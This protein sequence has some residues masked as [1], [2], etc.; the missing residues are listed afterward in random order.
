MILVIAISSVYIMIQI[1]KISNLVIDLKQ[2]QHQQHLQQQQRQIPIRDDIGDSKLIFDK[3]SACDACEKNLKEVKE[4]MRGMAVKTKYLESTKSSEDSKSSSSTSETPK[5][6]RVGTFPKLQKTEEQD[7]KFYKTVHTIYGLWSSDDQVPM[8]DLDTWKQH[9]PEWTLT[10]HNRKDSD[11][12]VKEKF[13]WL[14]PIYENAS[15]IQQADLLRLLFVYEYGGIY[16]DVDVAVDKPVEWALCNNGFESST[17]NLVAF[18]EYAFESSWVGGLDTALRNGITEIN[19]RISNY[20][21]YA[22]P[23]SPAL[24]SVIMNVAA[25]MQRWQTMSEE[26]R[27]DDGGYRDYATLYT[28]G[29][30]AFTE[31]VFGG[32]RVTPLNGVLIMSWD[33][34]SHFNNNHVGSW[35]T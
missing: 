4:I 2:Q 10:I 20:V 7:Q 22:S 33:D 18:I 32:P 3:Q 28:T 13:K 5:N 23:K 35:R 31:S 15:K 1:V 29:P 12:L 26:Q 25:R 24:M 11:D 17:H 27:S 30:D 19:T 34:S 8:K 16:A 6:Y 14:Q 21:F 9:N